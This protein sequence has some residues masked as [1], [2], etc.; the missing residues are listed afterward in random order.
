[1]RPRSMLLSLVRTWMAGAVL[2]AAPRAVHA[3]GSGFPDPS[4][5]G[6]TLFVC[7]H[8]A[9]VAI[10]LLYLTYF[11]ARARRAQE[12]LLAGHRRAFWIGAAFTILLLAGS[13]FCHTLLAKAQ[14][15]LLRLMLVGL[16]LCWFWI[17]TRGFAAIALDAGERLLVR[18]GSSQTENEPLAM[19]LGGV[20]IGLAMSFP[21]V[22]WILGA[23]AIC[24]A[25]GASLLSRR[26]LM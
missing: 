9:M 10:G 19:S 6:W 13:R 16:L 2:F 15:D 1:M 22:G 26:R 25:C 8:L 3:T 4:L 5:R 12:V 18:A 11:G 17:Y 21:L 20:V 7:F 23:Y 14:P 24:L